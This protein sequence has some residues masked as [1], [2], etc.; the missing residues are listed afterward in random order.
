MV[1]PVC[2]AHCEVDNGESFGMFFHDVDE[3]YAV[4]FHT[5]FSFLHVFLFAQFY[6]HFSFFSRDSHDLPW[7]SS[8]ISLP[9]GS[10]ASELM[11]AD[12][13]WMFSLGTTPH[14]LFF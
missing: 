9:V 6:M 13:L 11:A 10:S 1:C 2:F 5:I 8:R 7:S 12:T 3:T 4:N 14:D